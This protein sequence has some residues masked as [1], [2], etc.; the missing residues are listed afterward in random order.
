[1]NKLV[2]VVALAACGDA[3]EAP[4]PR[5]REARI[6]PATRA[7]APALPTKHAVPGLAQDL[8]DQDP[9]IRRAAMREAARAGDDPQ[10]FL[11]A[12]RDP[13][14]E[15]A[16]VATEAL[17]KLHANGELPAAELIARATDRSLDERVR[18]SA[19]N[20]FGVVAS[21]D[22]ARSLVE[23]VHRGDMLERR[24]AAILLV[25][26]DPELAIPALIDA[27]GDADEV[28]RGN[29]QE[30]LRGRA[31]GRDFGSDAGAW[32]SWWQSRSR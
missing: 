6:A 23:L 17:A 18:A 25:H 1:M 22:A 2:V 5:P 3:R 19:L 29:A 10:I 20:G 15:V 32:R 27:L 9:K 11:G 31:R 30:S 26:Q 16:I 14:R 4:A 12:S 8:R 7:A 13:D 24:S 21:P 28:V